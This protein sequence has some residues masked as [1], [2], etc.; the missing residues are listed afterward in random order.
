MGFCILEEVC[1]GRPDFSQLG[2]SQHT[3]CLEINSR[4]ET[5]I[6]I[7]KWQHILYGSPTAN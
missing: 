3:I 2:L 1:E 4:R 5:G 6:G 7:L